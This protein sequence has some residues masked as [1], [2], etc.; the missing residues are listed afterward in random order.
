[1][2]VGTALRT[3]DLKVSGKIF[4][5]KYLEEATFICSSSKLTPLHFFVLASSVMR[6]SLAVGLHLVLLIIRTI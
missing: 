4:H 1:M 3:P 6:N 5:T 2:K